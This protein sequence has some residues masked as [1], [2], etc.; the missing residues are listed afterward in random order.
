M[1][2]LWT[3]SYR[4]TYWTYKGRVYIK[5]FPEPTFHDWGMITE[6]EAYKCTLQHGKREPLF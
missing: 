4:N 5:R 1:T 3:D 2:Y 6:F